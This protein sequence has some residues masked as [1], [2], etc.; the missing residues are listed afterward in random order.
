MCFMRSHFFQRELN[1]YIVWETKC[2][3]SVLQ[4]LIYHF[5]TC[6]TILYTF[7]S[8]LYVF[9]STNHFEHTSY[10]ASA[11]SQCKKAQ[12]F[13]LATQITL[14]PLCYPNDT[15]ILFYGHETYILHRSGLSI[16][17][18]LLYWITFIDHRH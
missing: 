9:P 12:R 16:L 4:I 1:H 3:F 6:L 5:K 14:Y 8:C 10:I 18:T 13:L 11:I 7:F 15:S 2:N 17:I